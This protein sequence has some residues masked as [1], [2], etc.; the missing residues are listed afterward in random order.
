MQETVPR[1]VSTRV[2]D[3]VD[4]RP[5]VVAFARRPIADRTS[6]VLCVVLAF[7]LSVKAPRQEPARGG[8]ALA[9]WYRIEHRNA[10]G[11]GRDGNPGS[12]PFEAPERLAQ[13]ACLHDATG[14]R[15]TEG[16]LSPLYSCRNRPAS[17]V[18]EAGALSEYPSQSLCDRPEAN[19]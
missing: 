3:F 9:V 10:T 13:P 4:A 18:R 6:P 8:S 15:P 1:I 16:L 11:R 2:P 14:P 7:G 12:R 19:P 5:P 17:S